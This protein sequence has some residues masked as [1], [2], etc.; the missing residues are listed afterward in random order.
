LNTIWQII[1][2][3]DVEGCWAL[4][5]ALV[6]KIQ[7]LIRTNFLKNGQKY[8]SRW[9][10]KTKILNQVAINHSEHLNAKLVW[11]SNG[12]KLSICQIA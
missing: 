9:F 12:P 5:V 7:R 1:V 10:F 11:Y 8:T 6:Q 2:A 3:G 4:C